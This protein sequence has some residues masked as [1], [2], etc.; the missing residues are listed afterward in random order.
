MPTS[1]VPV[2]AKR[3]RKGKWRDPDKPRR[4]YSAYNFFA[5][6]QYPI[7]SKKAGKNVDESKA[8]SI[9]SQIA[10]KWRGLSAKARAPY[11]KKADGAKK[12]HGKALAAYK[13]KKAAGETA[14]KPRQK[15]DKTK[16]KRAKSA[17]L[18]FG[19]DHRQQVKDKLRQTTGQPAK[20]TDV[21][22]GLSEL[23][24]SCKPSAK[25]KYQKMADK[26]KKEYDAA[27]KKWKEDKKNAP[28]AKPAPK[29]KKTKSKKVAVAS[30]GKT[31]GLRV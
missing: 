15:R 25:A 3:G 18:F 4:P 19:D 1:N 16:P 9:M 27:M 21:M 24:K 5:K 30:G 10:A 28:K 11:Q 29:A 20:V 23:W 8:T 13:V 14:K 22:V 7:I 17:Y 31:P 12:D 26:A 6:E 2:P